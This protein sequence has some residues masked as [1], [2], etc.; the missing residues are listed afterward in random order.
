MAN[1]RSGSREVAIPVLCWIMALNLSAVP[2]EL[3]VG[4][5]FLLYD[6]GPG[7]TVHVLNYS[8]TV[9]DAK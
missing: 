8:Q 3:P 1:R 9:I 7:D 4:S 2:K 5:T 6:V